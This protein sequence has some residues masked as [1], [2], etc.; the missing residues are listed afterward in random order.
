MFIANRFKEWKAASARAADRGDLKELQ[1]LEACDSSEAAYLAATRLEPEATLTET[2]ADERAQNELAKRW[3]AALESSW[4]ELVACAST[5]SIS[6]FAARL[7]LSGMQ[8]DETER[9]TSPLQIAAR[10]GMSLQDAAVVYT[11]LKAQDVPRA[12]TTAFLPLNA[13][14]V[15][16][17]E[18]HAPRE[19]YMST[20]IAT[21]GPISV[22]ASENEIHSAIIIP[23]TLFL[24]QLMSFVFQVVIGSGTLDPNDA[25]D[26][27]TIINLSTATV[28]SCILLAS[29]FLSI[30]AMIVGSPSRLDDYTACRYLAVR[31]WIRFLDVILFLIAAT[32]LIPAS[33]LGSLYIIHIGRRYLFVAFACSYFPCLAVALFLL[34]SD[35]SRMLSSY[36]VNRQK[37]RLANWM[38]PSHITGRYLRAAG[39]YRHVS[40][41][42][43]WTGVVREAVAAS[44]FTNANDK[45]E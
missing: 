4:P 11:A 26:A 3:I 14:Y 18:P 36:A 2:H 12:R 38:S 6:E 39:R 5:A 19:D 32:T 20:I 23:T 40:I 22:V 35:G 7:A 16:F 24:S 17:V 43:D 8:P 25:T 27:A 30:S 28:G 45:K 34:Y 9:L 29:L 13:D 44:A 31:W 37:R 21:S 1:S 33:T 10:C 42:K 41:A 15:R